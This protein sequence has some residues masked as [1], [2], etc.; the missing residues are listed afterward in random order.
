MVFYIVDAFTEAAFGGNTAGVVPLEEGTDFPEDKL[1][2][3]IAAELRYSET[4][5]TQC[6]PKHIGSL[7]DLIWGKVMRCRLIC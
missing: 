4:A 1:M 5:F 7:Q 3:Q 2:E 6:S